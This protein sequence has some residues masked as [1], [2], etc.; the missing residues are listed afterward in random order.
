MKRFLGGALVV[1]LLAGAV[2]AGW[3]YRHHVIKTERGTVV[4]AKRFL[5]WSDTC[6][7][8][9]HW[10]SSDFDQHPEIKRVLVE[11]GYRDLLTEVKMRE[12]RQSFDAIATDAETRLRQMKEVAD[13]WMDEWL[14][15]ANELMQ[16]YTATNR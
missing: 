2:A 10:S 4:L 12:I 14:T 15:A 1:V 11:N 3:L 9:R 6:V 7:D 8:A 16:S 5:T 13:Q